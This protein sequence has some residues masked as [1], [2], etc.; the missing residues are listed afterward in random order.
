MRSLTIL[1][2]ADWHLDQSN[3]NHAVP[4]LERALENAPPYDL[5]VFAGDIA[6]HRGSIH[7]NVAWHA[8]RLLTKACMRAKFG[9]IMIAGN[10]D[11][12]YRD[13][14]MGTAAGIMSGVVPTIAD[15]VSMEV[16]EQ[17]RTIALREHVGASPIAHFVCI[18]SPSKHQAVALS[19]SEDVGVTT[20]LCNAMTR[21]VQG[22]VA[23]CEGAPVFCVYHGGVAGAM[24]GKEMVMR[25]G[26]DITVGT[27]A[28]RGVE[29]VLAGH[30]HHPQS[31][32]VSMMSKARIWFPGP[33]LSLTWH[34]KAL[35]PSMLLH[36]Y[37]IS[38][39]GR[40]SD[41]HHREVA[42][43]VLSNMI[44]VVADLHEQLP[45]GEAG[46][47]SL[48]E[49]MMRDA[50]AEPGDRV[51]LVVSG[52]RA[53]LAALDT[54]WRVNAERRFALHSLK[55][56]T[57]DTDSD[58]PEGVSVDAA[59]TMEE[60]FRG[61][62]AANG[63]D[64]TRALPL[65]SEIEAAVV[66][67]HLD[68]HYECKPV[69]IRARNWC[70]YA[71]INIEFTELGKVIAVEGPNFAGKSNIARLFM[72]ARYKKQ[73][74]GNLLADLVRKG[75][76]EMEVQEVFDSHGERYMV[77]RIVTIKTGGGA[78]SETF[79][80]RFDY[81][82][83]AWVSM[84]E[85]TAGETQDAID[86]L[87]G[88]FELFMATTYAGQND[89]DGLLNLRPAEMKDLLMT[90]LQRDFDSRLSHAVEEKNKVDM[91]LAEVER[92]FD[93]ARELQERSMKLR[94]RWAQMDHDLDDAVE[95]YQNKVIGLDSFPLSSIAMFEAQLANIEAL[96]NT[97][98]DYE[99]RVSE[100]NGIRERWLIQHREC[101]DA[102]E[103]L[104][105]IMMIDAPPQDE[106]DEVTMKLIRANERLA[107]AAAEF[108]AARIA[109]EEQSAAANISKTDALKAA[110]EAEKEYDQRCAARD[111]LRDK[112][113][114]I[115]TLPCQGET[116]YTLN[117][118]AGDEVDC[119]ECKFVL[120]IHDANEQ[121]GR[122]Y[123]EV[124]AAALAVDAAREFH[125]KVI[126]SADEQAAKL[127]AAEKK[128]AERLDDVEA[129]I[130]DLNLRKTALV[131]QMEKSL[132][133][134]TELE[135]AR[136]LAARADLVA[137]SLLRATADEREAMA[138]L[139]TVRGEIDNGASIR[140]SLESLKAQRALEQR[141]VDA[142]K[143]RVDSV[144]A[145]MIAT[146]G[147]MRE[148]DEMTKQ[149]DGLS[150]NR[151]FLEA[152]AA[153]WALVVQALHRDGIPFMM[154]RRFAIPTLQAHMNEYLGHTD[155]RVAVDHAAELVSGKLR[156]EVVITFDD[157]RG[158][159][160]LSSASGYQRTVIGM[161]LRNALADLHAA[162]TGSTIWLSI[163]DEGFGTMDE[164]NLDRAK[165]SISTIASR[166]GWFMFISHVPGMNEIADS[167]ISVVDAGSFS[168]A[169]V[170]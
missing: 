129:V 127:V 132:K 31:V 98:R 2:T 142:A 25:A 135:E 167:I 18:P 55:V 149:Y 10:H 3:L 170:R 4:A 140:R 121:A 54:N 162:A 42:V 96:S 58:I 68:A 123:E 64:P 159:H 9:G 24:L 65:I 104:A 57:E 46:V 29:D 101:Q 105:R 28:F 52:P 36:E 97:L 113:A 147:A 153:S 8:R 116:L 103:K 20:D 69:S 81:G 67:K 125:G 87:I 12:S 37:D 131:T 63:H 78:R 13:G 134:R 165:A 79:L 146:E 114:D 143:E 83:H 164:A 19:A 122:V 38:D 138:A 11:I 144:R 107:V 155:I 45:D 106:I 120:G 148:V 157:H 163:Q 152:K 108:D 141:G 118:G 112:L 70:Q 16:V 133:Q 91:T 130:E 14:S 30:L 84:A 7:P 72:F 17:P 117:S 43:P 89:V 33:P 119:G 15:G 124:E 93:A 102:K 71:A 151:D 49:G 75:E 150:E 169:E 32:Q 168:M 62:C 50:G 6:V 27:D 95:D 111:R 1:H 156:A 39:A 23:Q 59:L 85:G 92:R 47:R 77:R 160:P 21:M 35:K 90:V 76:T 60:M 48:M 161:A 137:D 26:T 166:R 74:S 99:T 145:G 109:R 44:E 41:R 82:A 86:A 136:T 53:M 94:E 40:V 51:R 115:A 73:V 139:S 61:W 128:A 100:T 154:L 22:M 66:D 80:M 5:F 88:P 34:D 110:H 56:V 126:F 158:R